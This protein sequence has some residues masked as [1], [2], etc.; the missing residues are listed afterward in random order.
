MGSSED[1]GP[2]GHPSSM[3]NDRTVSEPMSL[4]TETDGPS[5]GITIDVPKRPRLPK[6]STTRGDSTK[7]LGEALRLARAR[8]EQETLLGDNEEAD[9]DGCYPP[10]KSDEP[11]A[12]NPHSTLPIYTTIHK[13]RRLV[14]ASIGM[15]GLSSCSDKEWEADA[16]RRRPIFSRTTQVPAHERR[17]HQAFGRTSIRPG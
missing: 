7:R 14:I 6:R 3:S 12:P 16:V 5:P 17:R 13:I 15:L 2:L 8:E 10:R 1:S 4:G 11:R 9:D